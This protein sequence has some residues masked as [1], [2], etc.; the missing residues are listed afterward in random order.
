MLDQQ[1]PQTF[2]PSKYTHYI[3]TVYPWPSLTTKFVPLIYRPW[4][5]LLDCLPIFIFHPP[6]FLSYAATLILKYVIH[7]DFW[8]SE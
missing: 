5:I 8:E 2:I 1:K 3:Y 7:T 6:I 4:Q